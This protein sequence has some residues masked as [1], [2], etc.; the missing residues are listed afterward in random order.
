MPTVSTQIHVHNFTQMHMTDPQNVIHIFILTNMAFPKLSLW[1]PHHPYPTGSLW[2]AAGQADR[3]VDGGQLFPKTFYLPLGSLSAL[4]RRVEA[5][6]V[7][8]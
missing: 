3:A 5:G 8:K 4:G 7:T 6:A 1:L 2:G